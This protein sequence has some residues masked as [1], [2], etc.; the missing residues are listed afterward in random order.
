[1]TTRAAKNEPWGPAVNAGTAINTSSDDLDPWITADG[2]ELYYATYRAGG[3][4]A[5]DIWRTRRATTNDPWTQAVNLGALVNSPYEEHFTS[6]SPDGLLL[7]FS[8]C[9]L[10]GNQPTPRPGGYG[11]DDMWMARR[12]SLSEPW[13]SAVN[14]GPIVNGSGD[15]PRPRISPDGSVL[16]FGTYSGGTWEQWQ[17]SILPIVD[18]NGDGKVDSKDLAMLAEDWGWNESVCDIGPFAWGDG[19]V[20][21]RDL[22]VLSEYMD[23]NGP[24]VAHY[25]LSHGVEVPRDVVLS[26]TPGELAQSHDVYFGTSFADVNEASRADPRGVLVVEGQDV[27][28]YDPPGLLPWG[29]T[30]YWRVDAVGD[31]TYRG[32]VWSFTSATYINVDDFESYT[33]DSPNRVFQTWIDGLGF[34]PDEFF[35]NGGQSN[36][37]G[38]TVGYDPQVRDIMEKAIVH[39]GS[40]SMPLGYDGLSETT[41]TFDVARD[42]TEG[43][44][45]TLVVFFCGDVNNVPAELY[46]KIN[47]AKVPYNGDA[48]ELAV[49]EWK[50]WDIDLPAEAG[51]DAVKTLTIG[52]SGGRGLLYIDDIRLYP[53]ASNG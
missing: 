33:N 11:G 3:R 6:L 46:V 31:T 1:V 43:G 25:P 35:P 7:L 41:R 12:A 23:V 20:D 8:G 10:C 39:S 34:S 37:T 14:L 32:F 17:S 47:D 24:V 15:A 2:L 52:V 42:W 49:A 48:S 27:N 38:A 18:L 50:Q 16:I 29:Q 30:Y 26:W 51:L 21:G 19:I 9:R 4:G 44:I 5:C 45:T 28:A 36:G 40:Q 22:A 53:A 13:Q